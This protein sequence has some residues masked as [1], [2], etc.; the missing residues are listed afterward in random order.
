MADADMERRA[1]AVEVALITFRHLLDPRRRGTYCDAKT[2]PVTTN[3][4]HATCHA[5]LEAL[6][7]HE[8]ELALMRDAG[9]I[10]VTVDP[11]VAVPVGAVFRT[12]TGQRVCAIKA[13]V[14]NSAAKASI[15]IS[16]AWDG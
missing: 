6:K 4:A 16:V 2:F 13:A 14:N 12:R 8:V 9:S 10:W 1:Q 7:A 15:E 3:A 5:C 11:G